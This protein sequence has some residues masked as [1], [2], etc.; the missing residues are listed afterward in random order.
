MKCNGS[1]A[2]SD[3]SQPGW[4]EPQLAEGVAIIGMSG[5]FP[6]A[7][8]IEALWSLIEEGG[9]SF[10]SFTRDDI[11][12]AFT[13]EERAS[14]DYVASRPILDEV[15]MFDA[16]FF[17]M[18]PREA[19]VTDPQHRV[20]LEIC[21]EALESAGYDPLN[22]PD[23]VGVFAGCSMPTYLLNNVLGDREKAEEFT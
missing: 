15:D 1:M 6:G 16:E 21:W 17:G 18:F 9:S 22:C 23:L 5:R 8:S 11:E 4:T 14:P 19:A 20:F 2:Q 13:D 3:A 12:D 7:S 10:R